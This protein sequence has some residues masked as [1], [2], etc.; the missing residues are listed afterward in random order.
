M[1]PDQVSVYNLAL[2]AVGMRS[3]LSSTADKD[4][5]AEVCNLWFPVVR[6]VVLAGAP[7]PSCRSYSRLALLVE[8][9][10]EDWVATDPEPGFT[11]AYSA[12]SDMVAPRHL[13][14]FE[15]FTLSSRQGSKA[16]MTNAAEAILFYTRRETGIHLWE[17]ALGLAVVYALAAHIC[18]PLTG[19]PGRAQALIQQANGLLASAQAEANNMQMLQYESIPDWI[20]ARGYANP[21]DNRYF[22]PMGTLLTVSNVD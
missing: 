2:N 10:D 20:S 11:F 12:P 15:P 4:R 22:Y 7:W 17:D 13:S 1:I 8:R 5:G 9:E 21:S 6:D 18:N 16:I 19:K 3:N 14:T